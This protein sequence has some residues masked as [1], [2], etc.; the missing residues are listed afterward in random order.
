MTDDSR[1]EGPGAVTGERA[2][3]AW[4]ATIEALPIGTHVT[5]EVTSRHPFGVFLR[6]DGT[7]DAVGLAEIT[8]MPHSAVLPTLGTQVTG[9]VIWHAVHNFQVKIK[10]SE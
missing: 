5:G 8:A 4:L 6:I 7:P 2:R 10:L 1:P 9:E 3:N